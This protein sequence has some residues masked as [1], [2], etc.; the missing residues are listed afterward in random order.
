MATGEVH[1]RRRRND[2]VSGR[3]EVRV[4]DFDSRVAENPVGSVGYVFDGADDKPPAHRWRTRSNATSVARWPWTLRPA[5]RHVPGASGPD[6]VTD[7]RGRFRR[8]SV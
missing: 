8:K 1:L 6:A 4:E 5:N 3:Q 2:W 7:L